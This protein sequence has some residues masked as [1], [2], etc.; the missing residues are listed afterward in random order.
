MPATAT[1]PNPPSSRRCSRASRPALCR[2]KRALAAPFPA[3]KSIATC[4]AGRQ[5]LARL[6]TWELR[7]NPALYQANQQAFLR[8]WCPTRWRT[9]WSMRSGEGRGKSRVL[10]HGRQWQSVMRELFGL[11]PSTTHSFDLGCW[12][13]APSCMPAPASSIPLGAPPQQGDARRGPLSLP[14]L[15]PA[16]GVAARHDGGLSHP[17]SRSCDRGALTSFN[18]LITKDIHVSPSALPL[19]GPAGQRPGPCRQHPDLRAAKQ[20]LNKLYQSHPVTFYCGCNIK[21]S[22]KKM[23]PDWESCGYLPRKRRPSGPPA[24]NGSTWC[25]PGS[26]AT[27]SSAGRTGVARIAARATSSTGW[28]ETCTTSSPPS[29]R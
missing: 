29:A 9:C 7:F 24:S 5:G 28:R 27:S 8:K 18:C 12:P 6:Q 20:D 23:A 4:G 3:R 15:S 26:S 21:F 17:V 22:G 13:S 25:P 10:P 16:P 11:E 19:P 14:P 1:R 2:P